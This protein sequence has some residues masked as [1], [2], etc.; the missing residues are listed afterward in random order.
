MNL[1]RDRAR[2]IGWALI[3]TVCF[4]LVMVLTFRV[5]AIKSQVRLAERQIIALKREK[6]A[7]ETEFET[8]ANQQQLRQVNEVEFG[9]EAPGAQQYIEGERQLV[10][11]GKPRGPGAPEPIRVARR[12]DGADEA[13][14]FPAMVSPLTGKA[15]AAEVPAGGTRKP[16]EAADLK[17]RL[18][19][20]ELRATQKPVTGKRGVRQE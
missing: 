3:L 17:D 1:T 12:D 16:A 19:R 8:R 2:S 20:V 15:I 18:A 10:A 11:F 6:I 7:L 4:A 5:N 9:Y 14:T 13:S